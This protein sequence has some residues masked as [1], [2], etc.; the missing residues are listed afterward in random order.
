MPLLQPFLAPQNWLPNFLRVCQPIWFHCFRTLFPPAR[1]EGCD[2]A[3][4]ILIGLLHFLL[5]HFLLPLLTG[6]GSI[7]TGSIGA[8]FIG[9]G[10]IGDGSIGAGSIAAGSIGAGAPLSFSCGLPFISAGSIA[11]IPP[12][13][14]ALELPSQGFIGA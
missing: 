1:L 5:L 4:K 14:L 10:S 13:A 3:S 8:G 9:A 2:V 7:G 12:P 6:A 11:G